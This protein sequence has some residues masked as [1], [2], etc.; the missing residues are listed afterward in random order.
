MTLKKQFTL[1]ASIII[2]IPILCIAFIFI[3]N[4]LKS[5][6]RLLIKE[7]TE[8]KKNQSSLY[9]KEDWK[10]K[11]EENDAMWRKKYKERFFQKDEKEKDED[12]E[13]YGDEPK[14][15]ADLFKNE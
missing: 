6:D 13:D 1:L 9:N 5:S 14:T 2:T 12:N 4:Y 15:Y 11:Y 8:L 10:T 3:Y 7:Y